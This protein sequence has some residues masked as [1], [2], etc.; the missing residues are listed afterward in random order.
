MKD[1]IQ[2]PGCWRHEERIENSMPRAPATQRKM[3][4]SGK[5]I[6]D[7]LCEFSDA[8]RWHFIL[9]AWLWK[10]EKE[11]KRKEIGD[12]SSSL[13]EVCEIQRLY[14]LLFCGDCLLA[15]TNLSQRKKK[16]CWTGRTHRK[17]FVQTCVSSAIRMWCKIIFINI[18]I[19]I[20]K[21]RS[22][23]TIQN[24]RVDKWTE[25]GEQWNPNNSQVI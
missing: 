23:H 1:K 20:S 12:Q 21:V 14:L 6:D 18:Y 4:N 3:D 19:Y 2:C 17:A 16:F 10:K 11:K 7:T 8:P 5:N 9:V 24:S 25:L 15:F 22:K 13:Y